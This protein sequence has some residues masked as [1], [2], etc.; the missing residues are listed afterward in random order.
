MGEQ[1]KRK[2]PGLTTAELAEVWDRWGRGESSDGIARALNRGSNIYYVVARWGGIRP[3]TRHRC[4]QA[5]TAT[6]REEISRG[7]AYGGRCARSQASS[8][9]RLRR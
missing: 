2:R 4:A 7:I 6:E 1:Q 5:L 9:V 8:S 3:R